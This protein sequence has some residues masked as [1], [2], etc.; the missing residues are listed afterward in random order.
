[1]GKC[2]TPIYGASSMTTKNSLPFT[3]RPYLSAPWIT[4]ANKASTGGIL[5]ALSTSFLARRKIAFFYNKTSKGGRV[6]K[7]LTPPNRRGRAD[8]IAFQT[9]F[10]TDSRDLGGNDNIKDSLSPAWDHARQNNGDESLDTHTLSLSQAHSAT[11]K[12]FFLVCMSVFSYFLSECV[13]RVK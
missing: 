1:M 7:T 9:I 3:R 5:W 4:I 11:K 8:L 13:C 6:C 2:P 12:Y 10:L